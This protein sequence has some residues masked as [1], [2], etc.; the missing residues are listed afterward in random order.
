MKASLRILVVCGLALGVIGAG[1]ASA[2]K[3]PTTTY[4][5]KKDGV[6]AR[7]VAGDQAIRFFR[8]SALSVCDSGYRERGPYKW[9][10]RPNEYPVKFDSRGHF[11]FRQVNPDNNYIA[12]FRGRRTTS[13]ING[14]Y[15]YRSNVFDECFTGKS[16]RDFHVRFATHPTG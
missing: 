1:M 13:G 10:H 14:I 5:G 9:G 3:A 12:V 11:S 2:A 8:V 4:A 16:F 15:G 7:I 6:K